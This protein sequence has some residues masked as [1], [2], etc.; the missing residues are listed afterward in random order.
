MSNFSIIFINLKAAIAVVAAREPALTALLVLVWGRVSRMAARLERLVA[1]WR[2]GK[3]P[4][5]RHPSRAGLQRAAGV[6]RGY[7]T[8]AGWLAA[9]VWEARAYGTQL[10]HA[11]T[12]A[13]MV[14]FLAAVPQAG[15][16][17]RP[18]YRMLG[19]GVTVAR[20]GARRA[21]RPVAPALAPALAPAPVPAG[22]VLGPDGRFFYV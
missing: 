12:E 20:A 6:R 10:A 3:L 19:V 4:K 9:E 11:L 16:I 17:L 21:V 1:L 13:E 15:R 2:A 7:P 18:L 14:A 22:L 5:A 8:A